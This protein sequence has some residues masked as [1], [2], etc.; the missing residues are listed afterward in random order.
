MRRSRVQSF[1]AGLLTANSAPH[2]ATAITG[3]RHLT[4]LA[5]RESGP[6]TNAV[7]AG[8]NLAAGALLLRRSRRNGGDDWGADLLAFEAGYLAF[9]A[10][11]AGSERVLRTNS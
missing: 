1:A 11:M 10:W 8:L 4:P 7:W 2:L 6:A 3:R 5:G 9:A